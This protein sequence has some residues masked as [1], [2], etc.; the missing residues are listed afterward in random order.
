MLGSLASVPLPDGPREPLRA[1]LFDKYRIE[2]PVMA[3]PAAPRR[4]V[5]VSAQLYNAT[6]DY[7]RLAAALLALLGAHP[8][9]VFPAGG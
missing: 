8:I 2:V 3:W 7:E 9:P 4:L 6:A 1:A 5:R